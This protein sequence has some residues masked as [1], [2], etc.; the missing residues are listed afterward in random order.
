MAPPPALR[1]RPRHVRGAVRC[2]RRAARPATG[3]AVSPPPEP[4]VAASRPRLRSQYAS[5]ALRLL[6]MPGT[7]AGLSSLLLGLAAAML[8]LMGRPP[9]VDAAAAT[10]PQQQRAA[11]PGGVPAAAAASGTD[12]PPL[13]PPA[14]GQIPSSPPRPFP[15]FPVEISPLPSPGPRC[16]DPAVS[17]AASLSP[18]RAGGQRPP[19]PL[20]AGLR[21]GASVEPGAGLSLLLCGSPGVALPC[22]GTGAVPEARNVPLAFLRKAGIAGPWRLLRGRRIHL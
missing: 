8:L 2:G 3:A 15:A 9:P 14:A 18:P 11:L 17:P 12:H 6:A 22:E 7:C 1:A 21:R 5:A 4:L 20:P 19:Q 16:R 13:P 10:R